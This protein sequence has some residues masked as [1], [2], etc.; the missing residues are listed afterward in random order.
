MGEE[1]VVPKASIICQ[2]CARFGE[3]KYRH[4]CRLRFDREAKLFE[5]SK[6]SND[7]QVVIEPVSS[8]VV[9]PSTSNQS[10]AEYVEVD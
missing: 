4:R 2:H 3:T 1:N 9:P 5:Y 8:L 10:E 7:A 6:E